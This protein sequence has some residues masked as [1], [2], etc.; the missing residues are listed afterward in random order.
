M[1]SEHKELEYVKLW[2]EQSKLFWSRLQIAITIHSGGLVGWYYL[3]EKNI[4][5]GSMWLLIV[6]TLSYCLREIMHRDAAIKKCFAL[7]TNFFKEY[8]E[9]KAEHE[10]NIGTNIAISALNLLMLIEIL[11][12]L[13][14]PYLLAHHLVFCIS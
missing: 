2:M 8:H 4:W 5:M 1:D 14:A 9:G 6:V 10:K 11:L 12:M 7:K 3:H 13:F